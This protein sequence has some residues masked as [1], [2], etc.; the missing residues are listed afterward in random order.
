VAFTHRMGQKPT[1]N[2]GFQQQNSG[3]NMFEPTLNLW[4]FHMDFFFSKKNMV[5]TKEVGL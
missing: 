2:K 4:V 5:L 3:F 1:K